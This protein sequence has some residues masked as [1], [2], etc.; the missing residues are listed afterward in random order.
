MSKIYSDEFKKEI[1]LL[2]QNGKS[3]KDLTQTYDLGKNTVKQWVTQY[4]TFG[5]FAD[6]KEL[7]KEEKELALIRK[8]LS[9]QKKR[10]EENERKLLIIQH[11][12]SSIL[13]KKR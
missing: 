9:E 5:N 1:V 7:T 10:T 2:R 4:E 12:L 3:V 11:A 13:K 8:Q 6:R